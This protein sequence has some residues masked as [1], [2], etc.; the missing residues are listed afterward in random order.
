MIEIGKYG[1]LFPEKPEEATT[2]QTTIRRR[3]LATRVLALAKTRVEGTWAA[4]IDAVP[5]QNHDHEIWAVM[6]RGTKLGEST[7]RHLFPE[8]E[9]IPYAH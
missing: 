3:A 7:A 1:L 8:F 4:Y 2:W 5:G 9:G 6:A